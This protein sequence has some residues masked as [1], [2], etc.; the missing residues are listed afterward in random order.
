VL[1]AVVLV[2]WFVRWWRRTPPR[3]LQRG[4]ATRWAWAVVAGAGLVV[5]SVAALGASQLGS[6]AFQGATWGGG[7]ATATALVLA[8]AWH[9]RQSRTE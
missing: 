2:V 6:A 5:G 1:G 8:A 4:P 7:A 3:A 9:L